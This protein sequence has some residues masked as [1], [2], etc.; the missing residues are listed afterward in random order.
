MTRSLGSFD[1]VRQSGRWPLQDAKARFSELV[2]R[3]R[4]EGPQHVTVHGRDEVVVISV[5][6]FHSLKGDRTGEALVAAMQA[7][8]H[9]EVDIEPDRTVMP[10]R[11]VVL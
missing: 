1:S 11:D 5:E 8:P 4:S 2:R 3:V 10:V 9:C 7:S 6:E